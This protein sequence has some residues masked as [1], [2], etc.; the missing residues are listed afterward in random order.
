MYRR[1]A[2]LVMLCATLT[3]F[4]PARFARALP[5]GD[6]LEAFSIHHRRGHQNVRPDITDKI[7]CRDLYNQIVFLKK[8]RRHVIPD[9]P[10]IWTEQEDLD[11]LLTLYRVRCEEV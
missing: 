3:G 6:A 9:F 10:L 5:S 11:H 2:L 4:H 8:L 1:V 7:D